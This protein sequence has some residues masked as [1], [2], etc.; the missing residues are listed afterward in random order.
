MDGVT[1]VA[2]VDFLAA[3]RVCVGVG[4]AQGI[5]TG[6]GDGDDVLAVGV[7]DTAGAESDVVVGAVAGVLRVGVGGR[8]VG[9]VGVLSSRRGGG[10]RGDRFRGGG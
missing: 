6:V 10:S 1:A 4:D 3:E 7:V 5:E 2:G 9:V 8:V